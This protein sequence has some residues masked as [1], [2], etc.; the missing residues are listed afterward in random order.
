MKRFFLVDDSMFIITQLSQILTGAGYEVVG[1]ATNGDEAVKFFA[2]RADAIDI[3]TLD[4]T[5][6][7]LDGIAV[8]REIKA[9]KPAVRVM[10]VSAIGKKDTVLD[11]KNLG[12]EGYLIKPLSREK[13]LARVAAL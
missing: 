6:P 7:G 3:V 12:A 13:V 9:V 5:M 2:E 4:V 8:L 10:I 1:Y 11:A